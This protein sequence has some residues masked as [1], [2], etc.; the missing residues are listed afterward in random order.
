MPP[1]KSQGVDNRK[2]QV[3]SSP[4]AFS[5]YTDQG[6]TRKHL[7]KLLRATPSLTVTEL[8]AKLKVSRQRI[9][10]LC[11]KEGIHLGRTATFS[12]EA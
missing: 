9:Y 12:K 8:A 7:V 1:F 5:Q 3:Y 4:M 11:E 10:Q 6:R 2:F